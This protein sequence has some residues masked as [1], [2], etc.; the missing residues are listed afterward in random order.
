MSLINII[1][2][3][4]LSKPGKLECFILFR[5]FQSVSDLFY[6]R[7]L[8]ST[9]EMAEQ[10]RTKLKTLDILYDVTITSENQMVATVITPLM[11]RGHQL[12]L[13]VLT[14]ALHHIIMSQFI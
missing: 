8:T 12:R 11:L 3:V 13:V 4:C 2:A 9:I 1:A 5:L 6:G 14:N 10:I 7:K